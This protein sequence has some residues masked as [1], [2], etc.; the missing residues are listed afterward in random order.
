M[1]SSNVLDAL[2]HGPVTVPTLR[3]MK[4]AG[5]RFVMA[6][7]YDAVFAHI[8]DEGGVDVILVGDSLGMVIQGH[9]TTLP[10]TVEEMLYH[11]KAVAR[12]LEK[13]RLQGQGGRPLLVADMPFLSYQT[14][15]ATA[16]R[17]AGRM[18]AEG[19]AQAVKIEGGE[20]FAQ[21]V[22]RLV[23][24]GIPVMGHIGLTPQRVHAMGGF[25]VQGK[26]S[27]EA[28]R[29]FMDA[30]AIEQAG[31]FAIVLEGIP[32]SLA[33]RISQALSIPTIGIGAGPDCDGQVLVS[34]DFLGLLP[35]P[36]PRFVKRYAELYALGVEATRRFVHEVQNGLFPAEAHSYGGPSTQKEK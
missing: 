1:G 21:T 13:R 30:R 15:I 6:T 23:E 33:K 17:N 3:S 10:V 36:S 12:A 29:I 27:E 26:S 14:D 11:V 32:S 22:A 31:A 24:V 34:H 2:R 18:L 28:E 19:G 20:A 4:A 25:R 8:L 35:G 7:A 16:I 9:E 5:L